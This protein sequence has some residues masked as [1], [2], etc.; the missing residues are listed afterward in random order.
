[1]D[2]ILR[3]LSESDYDNILIGWWEDWGWTPPLKQML[4]DNGIGGLILYD[5]DT[6]VCA[7]Y[8]YATNSE[9][10]LI[11][12]VISNKQYRKKP[13]RKE[14]ILTLVDNLTQSASIAGFKFAFATL[15]S[16]SLIDKYI[17]VGYEKGDPTQEM[18]KVL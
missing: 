2:F 17:E 15:K 14:A 9:M 3:Q 4:P 7:G 1:M 13:N 11:E 10:C 5:G 18:I 6:P 12:Y 16:K 8:M